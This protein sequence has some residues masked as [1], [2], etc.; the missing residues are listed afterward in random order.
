MPL[1]EVHVPVMGGIRC[2]VQGGK[3]GPGAHDRGLRFPI[4]GG[5]VPIMGVRWVCPCTPNANPLR[6]FPRFFL[7][8][9]PI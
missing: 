5:Q 2:P 9:T 8:L 4:Q 1:Y 7:Y 6:W 3:G